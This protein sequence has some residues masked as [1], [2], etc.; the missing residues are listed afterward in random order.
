MLIASLIW[1]ISP[2][3]ALKNIIDIGGQVNYYF[4][5]SHNIFM[6]KETKRTI[7]EKKHC[8]VYIFHVLFLMMIECMCMHA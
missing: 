2:Y 1:L 8:P 3:T 5:L 7:S 4:Y 6:Q